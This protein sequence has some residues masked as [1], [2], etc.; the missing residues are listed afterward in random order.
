MIMAHNE[1]YILDKL[2]HMLDYSNND[3]YLHV[4]KKSN[5]IDTNNLHVHYAR[6][7]VIPSQN[8]A[9][10]GESQIYC[11]L[12]LMEE[13]LRTKHDYYHLISGVDLP[14]QNNSDI[15]LFFEA[16]KGKEFIGITPN[17]AESPQIAQR[18]RLHWLFQDRIG[19]NKNLLY[20]L[21]RIV[22]KIEKEIGVKRG[23]N[24]A[25]NFYGGPVWF[26]ITEKAAQ[27]IYNHA[28]WVKR[29]F[30]DTICCDEIYAQTIIGNSDFIRSINRD[31]GDSHAECLRYVRFNRE[32]PFTLNM[33]DFNDLVGSQC[34]FARK[35]GTNLK[36]EKELVDRIYDLYK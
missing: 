32:S 15:V 33:N 12:R 14:I 25:I 17:W 18:Y 34:L 31:S 8:V 2:I 28:D 23:R 22:T 6:L 21:S 7:V 5:I 11:V 19:K 36:E 35:F 29:R 20:C 27:V 4:D 1:P 13:A 9:W 16:N 10:G 3:I 24:E 30:K 26:S